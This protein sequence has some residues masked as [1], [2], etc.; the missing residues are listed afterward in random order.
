MQVNKNGIAVQTQSARERLKKQRKK[1]EFE[2]GKQTFY[3][4]V[5]G[6]EVTAVIPNFSPV[7]AVLKDYGWEL[8]K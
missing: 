5:D 7:V 2:L 1:P 4:I 3:T 8:V 6:V